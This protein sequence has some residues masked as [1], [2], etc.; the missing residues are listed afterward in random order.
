MITI[1]DLTALE[2]MKVNVENDLQAWDFPIE[3]DRELTPEAVLRLKK[4]S[5]NLESKLKYIKLLIETEKDLICS[6]N[7]RKFCGQD[8]YCYVCQKQEPF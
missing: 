7:N 2:Q 1:N 8:H 6:E 5:N 4:I 3:N